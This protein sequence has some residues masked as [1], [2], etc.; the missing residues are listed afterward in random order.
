MST[1][2]DCL[3]SEGTPKDLLHQGLEPM[4]IMCKIEQSLSLWIIHHC[5]WHPQDEQAPRAF[6]QMMIIPPRDDC[7][8]ICCKEIGLSTHGG[9]IWRG[10]IYFSTIQAHLHLETSQLSFPQLTESLIREDS[11]DDDEEN[12]NDDDYILQSSAR[13]TRTGSTGLNQV[14]WAG[15]GSW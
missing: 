7:I 15:L 6:I 2:S 12:D 10:K 11:K 1:F 9:L 14:L 8:S 4:I 13:Y 5:F 3:F